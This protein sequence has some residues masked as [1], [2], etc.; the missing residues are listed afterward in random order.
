MKERPENGEKKQMFL[1][2]FSG[3]FFSFF[4]FLYFSRFPDIVDQLLDVCN[5]L[6]GQSVDFNE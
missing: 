3:L 1:Y 6:N 2:P 5:L 4:T